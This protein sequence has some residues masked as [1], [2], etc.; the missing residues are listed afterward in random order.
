MDKQE[1]KFIIVKTFKEKGPGKWFGHFWFF[2]YFLK[3]FLI[4]SPK[5]GFVKI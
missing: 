1:K 3:W 5:D 2:N 4:V